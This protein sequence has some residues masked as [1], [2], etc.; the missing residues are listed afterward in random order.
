MS[1]TVASLDLTYHFW[2]IHSFHISEYPLCFYA[3]DLEIM[4]NRK[5]CNG[6]MDETYEKPW[7]PKVAFKFFIRLDCLNDLST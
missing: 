7:F 4:R 2:C 1:L 6:L 5:F 3:Y